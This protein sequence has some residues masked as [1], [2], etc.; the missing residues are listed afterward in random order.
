MQEKS[1][2]PGLHDE[3]VDA[4]CSSLVNVVGKLFRE[5][6]QQVFNGGI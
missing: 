6:N 4:T 1:G 2:F 3:L 5:F